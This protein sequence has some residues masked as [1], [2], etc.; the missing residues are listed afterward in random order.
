MSLD[1]IAGATIPTVDLLGSTRTQTTISAAVL[2]AGAVVYGYYKGFRSKAQPTS[3]KSGF[4][5]EVR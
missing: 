1:R 2:L 4:F 5:R 3:A